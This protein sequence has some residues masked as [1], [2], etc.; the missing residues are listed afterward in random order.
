MVR[1]YAARRPTGRP[2]RAGQGRQALTADLREH[3]LKRA[4]QQGAALGRRLSRHVEGQQLA[5]QA[6]RLRLA[7]VVLILIL[8]GLLRQRRGG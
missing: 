4:L 3:L 7:V 2:G 1:S 6:A 5:H 8:A